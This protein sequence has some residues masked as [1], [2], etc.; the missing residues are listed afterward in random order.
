VVSLRLALSNPTLPEITDGYEIKL[1]HSMGH[2]RTASQRR[3]LKNGAPAVG[4]ICRATPR[5]G[6]K[7]PA[8][9]LKTPSTI[10]CLD[11]CDPTNQFY[12]SFG[13]AY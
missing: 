5:T 11:H 13:D 9:T 1:H 8:K 3:V 12:R 10:H 7:L 4:V 6:V 2:D